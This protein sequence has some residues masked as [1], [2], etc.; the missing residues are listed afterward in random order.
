MH[1]RD[2]FLHTCLVWL[3]LINSLNV[4]NPEAKAASITYPMLEPLPEKGKAVFTAMKPMF[5]GF[6]DKTLET[7]DSIKGGDKENE[8]NSK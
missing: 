2:C 1:S 8:R 7:M 5:K 3:W 4:L 6:W